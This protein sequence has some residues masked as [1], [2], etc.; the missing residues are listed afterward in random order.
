MNISVHFSLYILFAE[1]KHNF[2]RWIG[3][4]L[5]RIS[6]LCHFGRVSYCCAPKIEGEKCVL[7]IYLKILKILNHKK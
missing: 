6:H 7:L 2:S 1:N 4:P 5:T 3:K